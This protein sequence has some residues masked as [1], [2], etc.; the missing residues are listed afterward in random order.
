MIYKI[1]LFRNLKDNV[2]KNIGLYSV[3]ILL[4]VVSGY[5]FEFSITLIGL[6]AFILSYSSVYILNDLYD[7][8]E[9]EKRP[10]K[11]TRKPLVQRSVEKSDAVRI[12]IVL[13]FIGLSLSFF[14]DLKFFGIMCFLIIINA[15]Y[16]IPILSFGSNRFFL[17]ES[18]QD[19]N[20]PVSFK[21]T[22]AGLPMVLVMQILKI[23]LPWTITTNLVRF[24]FLFALGF[25]LIYLVLFRGYKKNLTV[26]RS[27][28]SEPLLF[29]MA[30]IFFLLSMFVHPEPMIQA[31]IFLYIVAGIILFRNSRLIDKKVVS[32]SPAYIA[33]GII[34][35]F[36][37][38]SII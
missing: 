1:L 12:G 8:A 20:H 10:E 26:G 14:V 9:D 6:I 29:G 32:M 2:P 19:T 27:V 31:S 16:S 17:L 30:A 23:L 22:I 11:H 34:I 15:L 24:P 13:L 18:H 3:G 25:S 33:L 5:H 7:I 36:C 35:L 21:Y 38:I 28:I 4:L 37:L